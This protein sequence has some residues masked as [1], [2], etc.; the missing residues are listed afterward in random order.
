[1]GTSIVWVVRF[2]KRPKQRANDT[3]T[4]SKHRN[5]SLNGATVAQ[6]EERRRSNVARRRT[7]GTKMVPPLQK[8]KKSSPSTLVHLSGN[9][10]PQLRQRKV[11]ATPDVS[12]FKLRETKPLKTTVSGQKRAK[13][14]LINFVG[15]LSLLLKGRKFSFSPPKVPIFPK[16]KKKKKNG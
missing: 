16:K 10:W 14:L 13:H 15:C 2:K 8:T 7:R 9:G 4:I 1:M 11:R 5:P 6:A 3:A 12:I